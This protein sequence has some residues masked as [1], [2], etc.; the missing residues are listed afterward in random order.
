MRPRAALMS[1]LS[2]PLHSAVPDRSPMKPGDAPESQW[3]MTPSANAGATWPLGSSEPCSILGL[4]D[5]GFNARL[6]QFDG[7]AAI[8][9]VFV[10][11][12]RAPMQLRFGQ[13]QRLTLTEPVL[14]T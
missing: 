3:A 4:N 11:P 10:P 5:K 2:Q 1:D 13:F 14:P 6:A 7:R 8:A 12:A 9:T